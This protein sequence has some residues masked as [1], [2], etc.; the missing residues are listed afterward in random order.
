M[1]IDFGKVANASIGA[2]QKITTQAATTPLA[3]L[4]M[5]NDSF[6]G[7]VFD[8]EGIQ[9]IMKKF[10]LL[11]AQ[12]KE[13]LEE[14]TQKYN[15]TTPAAQ[16]G[17]GRRAAYNEYKKAQTALKEITE[18]R[19]KHHE[20]PELVQRF[21]EEDAK[22]PNTSFL[23]DPLLSS[24]EKKVILEQRPE[25]KKLSEVYG[26]FPS[27]KSIITSKKYFDEKA[28]GEGQ[29]YIDLSNGL[30]GK[31]MARLSKGL[32]VSTTKVAQETGMNSQEIRRYINSGFFEPIRLI[33]KQTGE[34]VT[35]R[36]IDWQSEVTQA[37]LERLKKLSDLAPK[38]S[39]GIESLKKQGKPIL[40]PIDYLSKIGFGTRTAIEEALRDYKIPIRALKGKEG[41]IAAI[42][43]DTPKA[44]GVL[45]YLE[46][47]NKNLCNVEQMA[48]K[49]KTNAT[50]IED[51]ILSGEI[52]PIK[53]CVGSGEKAIKI[54]TASKKN[55][56]F[57][58]RMQFERELHQQENNSLTSL[59]SKLAWHLCPNT[60]TAASQAFGQNE[61]LLKGVQKQIKDLK[62]MLAN[63][64][65]KPEEVE[66]LEIQLEKL[67]QQE[68][69]ATA[70]T[71]RLMWDIAGEDEYKAG[72][73]KAQEI[74][75]LIQEQGIDAIEDEEIKLICKAHQG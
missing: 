51:A 21:L 22:A 13:R 3:K 19:A 57:L 15:S 75:K 73:K 25:I 28:I 44:R 27:L 70:K 49:A 58:E 63:P 31:N 10:D 42:D 62:D 46:T 11:I 9:A 1:T 36:A 30:N 12:A 67:T 2:I 16:N 50:V 6:G 24:T 56:A 40:V 64:N 61:E 72:M 59:R 29:I 35:V 47:N 43:I 32:P 65:L 66:E 69:I 37:G 23:Y 5:P 33:D 45:Q 18:R 41:T 38:T 39:K 20:S 54:N 60:K 52:I 14:A 68:E 74:I 48:Q 26:K 34:E 17:K 8:E 7:K 53:E 55:Q 4:E 71:Y